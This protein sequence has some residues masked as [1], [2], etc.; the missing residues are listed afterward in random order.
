[1]QQIEMNTGPND[2]D[3]HY[4]YCEGGRFPSVTTILSAV[5]LHENGG[6]EPDY[7]SRWRAGLRRKH[8]DPAT[9]LRD[10]QNYGTMGHFRVLNSLS[11][12]TIPLPAV[13]LDEFPS[14]M[15]EIVDRIHTMFDNTTIR[16]KAGQ[17]ILFK[18]YIDA[19]PRWIEKTMIHKRLGFGGQADLI[20]RMEGDIALVDLKT[21]SSLRDHHILQLGAYSMLME[22]EKKIGLPKRCF[23][24][25]LHPFMDKN[26]GLDPCLHEIPQNTIET[27]RKEFQEIL[28]AYNTITG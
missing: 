6:M 26:P 15:L 25:R 27:A 12:T 9:H 21:S 23:I 20:C 13:D 16:S 22:E 10:L 8:I 4:Y 14:D 2:A 28:K 18:D 5:E 11:P 7:L 3:G 17:K 19:Y 1:M 24:L